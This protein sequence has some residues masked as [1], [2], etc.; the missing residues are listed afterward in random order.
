MTVLDRRVQLL[1]D[2]ETY[3][4]LAEEASRT[5]RSVNALI[6]DAVHDRFDDDLLEARRQR[7]GRR[8]LTAIEASEEEAPYTPAELAEGHYGADERPERA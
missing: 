4:R 1:L 8:L 6:R 2:Q 5:G 3:R 7:A